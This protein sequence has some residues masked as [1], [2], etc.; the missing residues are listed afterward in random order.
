M[1]QSKQMLMLIYNQCLP[2]PRPRIALI[3]LY[4]WII[5]ISCY[6]RATAAS[7]ISFPVKV[8]IGVIATVV[9]A[10]AV[11]GVT[12]FLVLQGEYLSFA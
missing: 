2:F 8:L 4:Q 1:L 3:L 12:V 11:V 9:V 5:N 6:P 7:S 10:A